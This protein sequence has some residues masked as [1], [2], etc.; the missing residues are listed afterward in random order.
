MVRIAE[1]SETER[2][3]SPDSAIS[4]ASVAFA[5]SCALRLMRRKESV[6]AGKPCSH[7]AEDPAPVHVSLAVNAAFSPPARRRQATRPS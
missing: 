5:G 4:A 3:P 1:S 7:A 2:T 6:V